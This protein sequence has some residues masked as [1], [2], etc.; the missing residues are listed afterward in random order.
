MIR[1]IILLMSSLLPGHLAEAEV[2]R[3]VDES[4]NTVYTDRAPPVSYGSAVVDTRPNTIAGPVYDEEPE[5]KRVVMYS[6]SWCGVCKKARAYFE[7]RGI[8]YEE[9]DVEKDEKGRRDFAE[10]NGRG[11]PIILVGDRR[12]RGFNP[13][14]FQDLFQGQD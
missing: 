3:Y 1:C 14:R 2:F 4:G 13:A 8:E 9:Y 5:Q 12:M 6:A 11:V 10:M 7:M